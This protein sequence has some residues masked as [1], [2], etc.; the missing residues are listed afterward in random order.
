MEKEVLQEKRDYYLKVKAELQ[1]RDAS[2]EIEE[3]VAK[4]RAKLIEEHE[5]ARSKDLATCDCYLHVIDECLDEIATREAQ[6]LVQTDESVA[7][8]E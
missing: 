8:A 6:E 1:A 5:Q 3:E 2:R 7:T 4:Y